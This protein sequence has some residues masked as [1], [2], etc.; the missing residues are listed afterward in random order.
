MSKQNN[1]NKL[2]LRE[3]AIES[4]ATTYSTGSGPNDCMSQ[5]FYFELCSRGVLKSEVYVCGW[6]WTF[7]EVVVIGSGSGSEWKWDWDLDYGSDDSWG[8]E[9][10]SGSYWNWN[11]GEG[12][13][14]GDGGGTVAPSPQ[15]AN[16]ISRFS[17]TSEE[18]RL[19]NQTL[20]LLLENCGYST[21]FDYL[22]NANV[23]FSN[24]RI[25]PN[26][27]GGASF[28]PKTKELKFKSAKNIQGCFLGEEFLHLYQDHL[29]EGLSKYYNKP[30]ISNIE[31]EAKLIYD[32]MV[33]KNPIGGACKLSPNMKNEDAFNKWLCDIANKSDRFP[34]YD[35]MLERN[36]KYKNLNYWDFLEEFRSVD[37]AYDYPSIRDFKPEV[38]LQLGEL[39]CTY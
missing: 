15:V 18:L 13:G 2:R 28:N 32:I 8:S 6:G 20:A 25:D 16:L 21:I 7:P 3:I 11:P 24:V 14:G 4:Q 30:G 9:S 26:M 10:G 35:M 17:L 1:V 31:F 5:E 12:G 36:P 27:I 29:Y 23:K 22:S 34:S 33:T 38:I 39:D 37:P 19:L